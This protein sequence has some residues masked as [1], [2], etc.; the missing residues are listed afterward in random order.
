MA[1]LS[2]QLVQPQMLSTA[3]RN[4]IVT[5]ANDKGRMIFNTTTNEL[6]HWD[7][8]AWQAVLTQPEIDGG[9]F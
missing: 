6:Q 8:T 7:G 3:D 1:L 2:A 4:L 5:G 9:A